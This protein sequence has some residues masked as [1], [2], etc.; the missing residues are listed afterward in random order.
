MVIVLKWPSLV[1]A[2]TSSV[3]L[4]HAARTRSRMSQVS[5]S[6]KLLFS[7]W[8]ECFQSGMPP[9]LAC[10]NGKQESMLALADFSLTF[11][12]ERLDYD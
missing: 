5:V 4:V 10:R 2:K 7:S 11:V 9:K 1:L 12:I 3:W 8:R 6:G